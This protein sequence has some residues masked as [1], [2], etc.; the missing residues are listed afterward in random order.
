MPKRII[1]L[2]LLLSFAVAS[3][4]T[5]APA[6]TATPTATATLTPTATPLP[7]ATA[8]ST[9]T[10]KPPTPTVDVVAALLPSGVPAS[11][12][13]GIPIMPEA[14]NGEGDDKGYS[15]TVQAD[16]QTIRLFYETELA[17]LGY[18]LFA[19]GEGSEKETVLMIFMNGADMITIA[20]IP[21]GD[22]MIVTIVK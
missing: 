5:F 22:L 2:A 21:E 14:I 9:S 10:P 13:K 7:T 18:T 6:P 17:K 3:C 16:S 1:V 4:S 11:D 8:T 20:V 12:W 15:F 19:T